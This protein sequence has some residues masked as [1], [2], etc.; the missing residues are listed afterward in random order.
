MPPRYLITPSLTI[1][2]DELYLYGKLE[3][4][5]DKNPPKLNSLKNLL[6]NKNHNKLSIKAKSKVKR[7]IKYLLYTA[8]EKKVY[9]PKFNSSYKFKVSFITLTLPSKQQHSDK[10]IKSQLLNQFLIEA[11]KKWDL[12]NYVWKAERQGNGNLHFHILSDKFIPHYELRQVWN[13]IVNKL[14]YVDEYEK[15]HKKRNPNS[16]DI[17]SLYKVKNIY[18]YITKY[19]VKPEHRKKIVVK[20]E[21]TPCGKKI[22]NGKSSVSKG[23]QL[24]LA[25]ESDNGRIWS[26]SQSMSNIE[27]GRAELSE[28]LQNEVERLQKEK[29]AVRKDKDY[30][31]AIYFNH[32][33][34]TQANYPLLY[35]LFNNFVSAKFNTPTQYIS[36]PPLPPDDNPSQPF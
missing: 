34:I 25:K 32:Y 5:S 22:V 20:T 28:Q 23:A 16:T 2:P 9:N 8:H 12:T 27:G 26:C 11:K 7:S 1:H 13:R 3:W 33:I 6:V 4:I 15:Q 18:N 31:T 10:I 35:T 24:F 36:Y 17:H 19:M 21:N 14:G 29:G 30:I